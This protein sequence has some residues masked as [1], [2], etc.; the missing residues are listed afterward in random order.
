MA[1][2][3]SAL[4]FA[5]TSANGT[6]LWR[7]D[8]TSIGTVLLKDLVTGSTNGIVNSGNPQ[9]FVR[10]GG[11]LFFQASDGKSGVDLW[12]TDGT[13][14]GTVLVKH[15]ASGNPSY[16][17][18]S[19]ATLLAN[20]TEQNGLLY[21]T[22]DTNGTGVELWRSD[23]TTGGTVMVRNINTNTPGNA[24]Y[25]GSGVFSTGV[26]GSTS[27]FTGFDLEHGYELWKT[28]GT[29]AG[30]QL[31]KDINPGFYNSLA[32]PFAVIGSTLFFAANDGVHGKELWVS[33]GTAAHTQML[34]DINPSG[35]ALFNNWNTLQF[36]DVLN[37]KL[38]FVADNG[39][40][41]TE[42]WITDG[43]TVGTVFVSDLWPGSTMGTPNSGFP[44]NF[45]NVGSQA[46]FVSNSTL[47]NELFVTDGTGAGTHIVKDI[48]PGSSGGVQNGSSINNMVV[49]NGKLY[50]T[51]DDVGTTLDSEVWFSDGTGPGTQMLKNIN[52]TAGTGSSPQSLVVANSK[53]FFI[54]NDG[55]NGGS[56]NQVWVSD[57]TDFGTV[58]LT[59]SAN[60]QPQNLVAA[61]NNVFFT[62]FT[63]AAGFEL[64][65]SNG[66]GSPTLLDLAGG[67]GVGSNPQNLTATGNKIFFSA[68]D[69]ITHGQELW[70]S[71]GLAGAGHTFMVKDI[72][73]TAN[74]G[75]NPSN[76][77]A[78]GNNVFFVADD[79]T[80]GQELWFSDGTTAGTHLVLDINPAA[81]QGSSPSNMKRLANNK[82]LFQANDGTNGVEL[83]MTDGVTIGGT[84]R[85]TDVLSGEGSSP[86]NFTL[87]ST[88]FLVAPNCD[89]NGD[90][91]TDLLFR[92]TTTGAVSNWKLQFGSG[93][94]VQ[95]NALGGIG[96]NIQTPGT[97][98][99]NA[100]GTSD[101]LLRDTTTGA[102]TEWRIANNAFVSSH[103]IGG[104]G[105]NIQ[106]AGAG[107]F[108]NDGTSDILLRDNTTGAVTEW[109][110]LNNAFV[111]S[112]AL[113]GI[114][115]NV[116][117][118]GVGDFN[119]DGTDDVLFRDT[120]TGAVTEWTIS[121][122]AF[123][124]S[125]ALGGIGSNIQVAGVGDFNF[126]G[127][128]DVLL[129]D[130]TTGDVSYW[131]INN[132]AFAGSTQLG[133]VGSNIQVAKV[134]DY[135]GDGFADV[136]LRDT[137]TSGVSAWLTA[138][139]KFGSSVAI[140]GAGSN[141]VSIG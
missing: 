4:I 96:S 91:A 54:A 52:T 109:G 134:G 74:Q 81:T 138:N 1:A 32:G 39:N 72:N 7:S 90:A 69:T 97:G 84:V 89:F 64:Y 103:Q 3:G 9:T 93:Q 83:W 98:D 92:D 124:G 23:G 26:V 58:A 49:F 37:N 42:L 117:I 132:N 123:T 55:G 14:N 107:D 16:S 135:N 30:T 51:A 108:N 45:V 73:P 33:D 48:A 46:F 111:A 136:L 63:A 133:G 94:F 141:V 31:V 106:V 71:D 53:L 24:S 38:L 75:S 65:V 119:G 70:V 13:A 118:A 47:G 41:G 5:N 29:V 21:F 130:N 18:I 120:T 59:S 114:S 11:A 100:D 102:V 116:Q 50:F 86:T 68:T 131:A 40:L 22:A 20:M 76:F 88:S 79:G 12:K 25:D 87:L 19:P 101:I 43:T 15:I 77:F 115:S 27:Y 121:N 36:T 17:G 67:A 62:G 139:G 127:Y 66:V 35:D 95:A 140:G 105:G 113:G 85:V 80:H 44:L 129:R 137:I 125:H 104:I 99:F 2:L 57:G 126:D 6:E 78:V 128:S 56:N 82:V 110:V 10:V 60:F 61:G 28:D 122:H 34:L 112:H 8:G